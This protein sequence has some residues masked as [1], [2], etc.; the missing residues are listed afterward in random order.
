MTEK[1]H[2]IDGVYYPNLEANKRFE[3]WWWGEMNKP[4]PWPFTIRDRR[5]TTENETNDEEKGPQP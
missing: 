3:K 4:T 5:V 2:Q 1:D